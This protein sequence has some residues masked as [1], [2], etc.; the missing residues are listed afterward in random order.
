L[1]LISNPQFNIWN[2]SYI[3]GSNDKEEEAR[4]AMRNHKALRELSLE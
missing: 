3:T 2:I 1:H 4:K